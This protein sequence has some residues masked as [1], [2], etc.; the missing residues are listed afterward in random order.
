MKGA[1]LLNKYVG[2]SE[3]AV[4]DVFGKAQAAAPCIVFFD[5]FD[6]LAPRRGHDSTFAEAERAEM[7][8]VQWDACCSMG[9][10]VMGC[11]IACMI[12]HSNRRCRN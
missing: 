12:T 6:A 9:W 7:G 10:W 5:E 2:A 3:Q 1:E 8:V 4:R 11:E